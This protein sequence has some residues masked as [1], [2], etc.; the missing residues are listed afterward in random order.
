MLDIAGLELNRGPTHQKNRIFV[1]NLPACTREELAQICTVFGRVVGSMIRGNHGF[2]MFETERKANVAT[3]A[4]HGSLFKSKILLVHNAN[5]ESMEEHGYGPEQEETD[6]VVQ[7]ETDSSG[8]EQI[9]DCIIIKLDSEHSQF[10]TD[11]QDEL[12]SKGLV[13]EVRCP[14]QEPY[15]CLE[16]FIKALDSSY[17]I[18]VGSKEQDLIN[19]TV[20]FLYEKRTEHPNLSRCEAFNLVVS[21]YERRN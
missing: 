15:S 7:A 1:G 19:V 10:A 9:S 13:V 14:Y 3:L 4:L 17:A 20:H 5:Y 8:Q 6:I 11:F 12:I 16:E 18:V 2:V 21:D